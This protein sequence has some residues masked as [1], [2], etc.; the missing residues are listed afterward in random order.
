MHISIAVKELKSGWAEWSA[1]R[2]RATTT[3]LLWCQETQTHFQ[4]QQTLF[5]TNLLLSLSQET[6]LIPSLEPNIWG[7]VPSARNGWVFELKTLQTFPKVCAEQSFLFLEVCLC[8]LTPEKSCGGRATPNS[9]PSRS[10]RSWFLNCTT[11]VHNRDI[12]IRS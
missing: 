6:M 10:Y 1:V 11:N 4:K 12:C 3:T 5:R 9:A 7:L 8:F 2:R